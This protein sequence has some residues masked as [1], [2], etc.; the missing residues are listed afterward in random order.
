VTT[1][2]HSL[3]TWIALAAI[4]VLGFLLRLYHL[5]YQSVWAD[6]AFS[7]TASAKPLASLT[8][9]LVQRDRHPPLHYYLLHF[10]F[11]LFGYG[12]VQA[13]VVSLIFGTLSIFVLYLLAKYLFNAGTGLLSALLLAVSQLGVAYS[14][15][16]RNYSQLLF[17]S[18]TATY[19][20]IVA[21]RERRRLWWWAAV[22]SCILLI[23]TH[24][25][26][27][28]ILLGLLLFATVCRGRY[29]I[30]RFWRVGGIA[31]VA[32]CY[33][34]WLLSGVVQQGLA[35][36]RGF[37]PSAQISSLSVH[38]Y[39]LFTTVNWFNN[40]KLV[41]F[42]ASSPWWAYLFGGL[43]FCLP[44]LQA[45]KLLFRETTKSAAQWQKEALFL[46]NLLWILPLLL[47]CAMGLATRTFNI[48]FAVYLIGFYYVLVARGIVTA[49][50]GILRSGCIVLLSV[51][52]LYSLRAIY[53]VPYKENNRDAVG[54]VASE[55]LASDCCV[56]WPGLRG[57]EPS[58]YWLVYHRDGPGI[59]VVDI[60]TVEAGRADCKRIW[61]VMDKTWWRNLDT[62]RLDL[63]RQTVE[64]QY[65]QAARREYFG[66]E[67]VLYGPKRE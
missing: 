42:Y 7:I 6:E 26:G 29:P 66:S 21:L 47:V 51:Y 14:Q 28:F 57:G 63:V 49:R 25:Y 22:V 52:S 53:C 38:W 58:A 41:G 19:L 30:P 39:T 24:Y 43:L 13:R 1:G 54:Y 48:R 2:D 36:G 64:R 61:L 55:Y 15:E 45:A 20:F 18:I 31:L 16:A 67:V 8:E 34:P 50:H 37:I 59:R 3:R 4:V 12:V 9:F 17:L 11:A 56:F 40:G 35:R 27:V 33:T 62:E 10:V 65:S 23:Y 46:L 5:D 44:V 32:L 60:N